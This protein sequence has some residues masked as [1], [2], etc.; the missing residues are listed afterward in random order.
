MEIRGN[1]FVD[2][3]GR[4]LLLRGANLGGSTKVP[5]SPD[6]RSFVKEGFYEGARAVSFVGRPFPLEAAAEHFDRLSRWGLRFERFLVTWEAIEHAGPGI[7]DEA[8]LDYV[9]ALVE[10]AARRG[11]SLFLDPHQDVWSRWTGGDGAPIWTL[12]AVGFEPR[13]LHAS[14]AAMLHQELGE[15]YPQMQWFSNYGRLACATMFTL[16]FAGDDF[17][18]SLRIEG[19]GAQDW[20]VGRYLGA[21]RALAARLAPYPNVVGLDSLNEP[22]SG[23]ACQSDLRL[24]PEGFPSIGPTPTPLEAMAAGEGLPTEAAVVGLRGLGLGVRG[25]A[26]FG[27]PGVRAW[28][29]GAGCP[30]RAE[31]IWEERDGRALALRPAWFSERAAG[32]RGLPGGATPRARQELF[33]EAYLKPFVARFADAVRGAAPGAARYA[34]FIEGVPE[35]ARPRYSPGELPGIANAA[36]WYD[37]FTLNLKRWTG[38]LAVDTER[39]ALVFGA[40]AV[41]L[42]FRR[43]MERLAAHSRREMAGA[44]TLLGEFGL[45][46]DLNNRRAF[47]SGDYRVHEGAL[48][49]YYDAVDAALLDSTIWNYTA[50]NGQERGDGW[51]GEDLSI[52]CADHAP[53]GSRG[54]RSE[55]GDP[56]DSGGRALRGFVRPYALATAGEIESMSFSMRSGRFELAYRPDPAV[57]APSLVFVPRLQYPRGFA[58]EATGCEA[59]LT[60]E[61]SEGRSADR[62][63][64][65][66]A[67]I[68]ALGPGL[69]APGAG[70]AARDGAG[71][72][73]DWPLAEPLLL[74]LR[75]L[76]GA[77]RCVLAL[78]RLP[79]GRKERT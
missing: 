61:G 57:A 69:P 75:A 50:D 48:A 5:A 49:A 60:E 24:R 7:Y 39:M 25:R 35:A 38:F 36:H 26:P 77:A 9:E 66:A 47:A 18:P 42:Y 10:E 62:T 68:A 19:E 27:T 1:R 46:F 52:Y 43:A 8:Y 79:P 55:T 44:P 72:A 21:I 76:P 56:R 31:G 37:G 16:F 3:E 17:A 23:W 4:R 28:R 32:G 2:A 64:G 30:W 53:G 34:I 70:G 40:R 11:I 54:E 73:P 29:E 6:G 20:L 71:G 41:R 59:F 14:G 63:A 67:P 65:W 33:N 78:T 15:D 13:R 12:E 45:P 58:A 74:E 22:G 51:N